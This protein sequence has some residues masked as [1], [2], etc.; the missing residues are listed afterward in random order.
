MAHALEMDAVVS[1]RCVETEDRQA[2]PMLSIRIVFR[3]FVLLGLARELQRLYLELGPP[4][5]P[6]A[7]WSFRSEELN[8]VLKDGDW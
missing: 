8:E 1:V 5:A 7:R 2:G 4:N 3:G 6:F